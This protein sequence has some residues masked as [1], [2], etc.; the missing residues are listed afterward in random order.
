[1]RTEALHIPEVGLGTFDLNEKEIVS[2]LRAGYRLLDTAWQ[3]GN[4]DQ[5]GRAVKSSGIKREELVITTKL[6]T[7]DIRKN[8]VREEF[9]ES[10]ARLKADYVDLYL[11][12][13]PAEGF[14][15]A[16]EIMVKL[17]EEGKVR[18]LGVSNFNQQHLMR[19][20][21][22]S[23]EAPVLNQIECH[24]LFQNR[25]LLRYCKSR[26]LAVQAWCPLGGSYTKITEHETLKGLA[27]KYEKTPAQIILRWHL[28]S[29]RLIIPRTS[30]KERLKDNIHL[31]DFAIDKEDMELID[32]M[33]T[34]RRIGADPDCFDF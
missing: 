15:K 29:G 16:W 18:A 12:H 2:G 22:I 1:M 24:P 3:Y 6:W 14:E 17:K 31:F 7:E 25:D 5:V 32:K 34:G 23:Q 30:K 20:E 26:G 13:W 28:Q 33:D 11:I 21:E 8:R 4:E 10:L 27:L 9:E 19:L